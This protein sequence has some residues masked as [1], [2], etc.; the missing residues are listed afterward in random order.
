MV[1]YLSRFRMYGLGYT[2]IVPRNPAPTLREHYHETAPKVF[3][4]RPRA[5]DCRPELIKDH[6]D[7]H[8]WEGCLLAH[9]LTEIYKS[10]EDMHAAVVEQ[11]PGE[12]K[13][14]D[15][16]LFTIGMKGTIDGDFMYPRGLTVTLDGDI[17]V[18]DTMN[19]RIQIFNES[20]VFKKKFGVKG[21][22][23]TQLNEP[24]GVTELPNGDLAVADKN[25]KR[26]QV[27][28]D[29]TSYKFE[30]PTL[31]PPYSI[32]CDRDY[33]IVVCTTR[34]TVEVYRRAGKLLNKFPV[35]SRT[36]DNVG[37]QICVNNKDEV[38]V[39]DSDDRLIK[40]FSYD[41]RLLYRFEPHTTGKGL[42]MVPSG[43]CINPLDQLIIGD[44]LN[45]TINSYTERGVLLEQLVCPTDETGTVEACAVG[46]EGHLIVSEF[47]ILGRHCLKIFRYKDP[48]LSR[49]SSSKRRTPTAPK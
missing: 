34:K 45:H 49:P 8:E 2:A 26:V 7:K 28:T 4:R 19:H 20:G 33:N 15:K 13:K 35:G 30:F 41:G 25:N 18:A 36:K 39:S 3:N 29:D 22:G 16:L 12:K 46:P 44:I 17:V 37:Y 38:I 5:H 27:F 31:H 21:S 23:K 32:A 48:N 47:S 14:A 24:T 1:D 9:G 11:K 6:R 42:A 40:F 10:V 43:I